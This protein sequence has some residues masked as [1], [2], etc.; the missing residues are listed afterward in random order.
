MDELKVNTVYMRQDTRIAQYL[1]Y[2]QYLLTLDISGTA[3]V[4]YA[5]LLN[6]ATLSQKN[7]W[8]DEEGKVYIIYTIDAMVE[9][10]RNSRTTIKHALSELDRCGLLERRPVGFGKPNH[11]YVKL[12]EGR[13]SD[14]TRERNPAFYRQE[15]GLQMRKN[16]V[17][18]TGGMSPPNNYKNNS[19]QINQ[20]GVMEERIAYGRYQN[21]FLTDA[22]YAELQADFPEDLDRFMEE[23]SNYLAASGRIYGNYAAGFRMWASKD[24]KSSTKKPDFDD[25]SCEEGESF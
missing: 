2:P 14:R 11:L 1:P 4:L 25:Y 9:D 3:T 21:I 10:L 23:M 24:K 19:I 13:F 5:L 12:P 17:S 16:S 7:T 8:L 18:N 15:K 20:N 22:E 6:R